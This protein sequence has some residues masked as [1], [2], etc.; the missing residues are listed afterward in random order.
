MVSH[1]EQGADLLWHEEGQILVIVCNQAPDF[2][3]AGGEVSSPKG[4]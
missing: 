4:L 3:F 1:Q 2:E